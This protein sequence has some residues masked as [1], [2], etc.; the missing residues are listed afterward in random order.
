MRKMRDSGIEWI[1]KVPQDWN[2]KRLQFCLNEQNIK[3]SPVKTDQ[4]LSLVKDKGVMLYEDKGNQGNKAK[5]D[6]SQYK[7]AYP[8][9]LIVNSMNILI[10]SVGISDYFGCVSPVYYVF[11]ETKESD[12]KYINYIFNTREFQKELRKYAKG[13]L[14][15]RLRV[16]SS[17]IFKREIPF[18]NKLQQIKIANFLDNKCSEIDSLHTDIEKQLEILEEYKKSVITEAVTKGLNPNVEMKESGIEWIGKIPK[19]WSLPAIK[20]VVNNL[21]CGIAATPEYVDE[22][23][24]ILFL[25]AQNIQNDN[26]DLSIKKYIPYELHKKITKNVKPQKGDI[27][28]VRVGASIGKVA[29]VDIDDEFSIYVSLSLIKVNNKI[30]NTYMKYYLSTDTF[31]KNAELFIDFAGTQGNL[32]VADLKNMRLPLPPLKEQQEISDY[33]DDKCSILDGTIR[34]KRKQLEIL[35]EYKKSLIYEYV[36]GKKEVQV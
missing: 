15:I 30:L 35:E 33:L 4:V 3:N 25:S 1:G 28:Q 8:H 22:S 5:D 29:I 14:E 17:D 20:Y 36:T 21:V 16:S 23:E 19:N 2:V 27:L 12:I 9:T 34:D 18:P 31:R 7:L 26:V 32:N 13:I 6:V 11:E 10:G 24:G